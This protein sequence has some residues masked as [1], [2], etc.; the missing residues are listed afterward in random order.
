MRQF[1]S[2]SF[3]WLFL[4]LQV[5]SGCENWVNPQ[6]KSKTTGA[7][8]RQN[9]GLRNQEQVNTFLN[10]Y[11]PTDTFPL[12]I[13]TK[14]GEWE[15]PESVNFKWRGTAMP[16]SFWPIF[17]SLVPYN[18]LTEEPPF[19]ATKRFWVNN[20]TLALLTRVPGEY[21]SSQ[22][23]LFLFDTKAYKITKGLRVAEAWGDAGDS[24]YL[25]S[26]IEK[27]NNNRYRI[28]LNQGEC[29]PVDENYEQLACTDS[30]KTYLLQNQNF[31]LT[32][33]IKVK[34]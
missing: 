14:I 18:Q 21:W 16:T 1:S 19:F 8:T 31:R 34:E 5:L 26:T 12:K 24:F 6:Y 3:L 22:V 28:V 25:E 15:G 13:S 30:L 9:N 32:S 29:H 10:F 27:E 11:V 7:L 2:K 17:N 20:S 33:A 23:Y 4:G